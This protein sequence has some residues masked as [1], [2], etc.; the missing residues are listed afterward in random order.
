MLSS[1]GL[2][3]LDVR[4]WALIALVGSMFGFSVD[5]QT[6]VP[7][8]WTSAGSVLLVVGSLFLFGAHTTSWVPSGLRNWVNY[9]LYFV[10][11]AGVNQNSLWD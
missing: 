4:I 10:R 9:F 8:F 3:V 2:G 5:L 1:Y 11:N 6:G 7:R